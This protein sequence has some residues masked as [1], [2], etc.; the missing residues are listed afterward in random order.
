MNV[1]VSPP[2]GQPQANPHGGAILRVLLALPF[3]LTST[4]R[5]CA[6]A[7]LT[8]RGSD[9]DWK[10]ENEFMI[11]DFSRNPET[12]RSGQINTI[13]LKDDIDLLLTRGVEN[14]TLHLSPNLA[15]GGSWVGT[16]RW[17][18]PNHWEVENTGARFR[19][20][21]SGP[22]P[23]I[24]GVTASCLYEI[25]AGDPAIRIEETMEALED[26]EVSL[27]RV[28]ELSV[29]PDARNPFTHISWMT[30]DGQIQLLKREKKPI[31]PLST[32]WVAFFDERKKFGIASV[33]SRITA[34]GPSSQDPVLS[35]PSLRFAGEPHYFYRA[36]VMP[37]GEIGGTSRILWSLCPKD[38]CTRLRT[39]C[40][41][42]E[43]TMR[44]KLCKK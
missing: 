5:V 12:G 34:R 39:I 17:N 3:L 42:S 14:S 7:E 18:P 35:N 32:R 23:L 40:S 29:A 43:E 37:R 44:S 25:R 1:K 15:Q 31:L 24:P 19:L 6:E 10:V 38:P 36:F 28:D 22:M 21:R 20:V 2:R 33:A 16:N 8:V 30:E 4:P 9:L 27:F 41:T 11:V 13:F 26:V